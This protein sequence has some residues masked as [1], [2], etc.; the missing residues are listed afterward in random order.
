MRKLL[1]CTVQEKIF[2]RCKEKNY[3][4]VEPFFYENNNSKFHLKC[5]VDNHEWYT[6][7]NSFIN[8]KKGCKKCTGSLKL[9]QEEAEKNILERCKEKNYTLSELFI[10]ENSYSKFHLRCNNDGYE[11]YP[12]YS[13]FINHKKGCSKCCGKL[14]LTQQEVEHNVLKICK[15]KN[16]ELIESFTYINNKT[17][18][19][20]KCN[21]DKYEWYVTYY[22]LINSKTG[23]P[24]CCGKL[25]LT[26]QEAEKN[27]LKKCKE[28]N[29]ELIEPFIYINNETKILLR[30]DVDEYKWYT[31]YLNFI[32][33]DKG[34]P[35]CSGN[36]KHTQQEVEY[37][38][39]KMCK[40]KNYEL[41]KP[42]Q[43]IGTDNTKIF[44]KCNVD[45][46]EWDVKYNNFINQNSGCPKCG[47]KRAA[48]TTI[49]RYGEIYKKLIPRYNINSIIYLDILSE[50]LNLPIQHAL[51]GGEKK[52]VKYWA[53]G[54][55]EKYNICIEWD[56]KFHKNNKFIKKDIIREQFL[57]ENFNCNIIRINEKA[58]LKDTDNQINLI[59]EKINNI[60][61]NGNNISLE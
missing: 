25:K 37:N 8:Y 47:W 36:L 50:K 29:Y 33:N 32:N 43:Y 38:V 17:K 23:C 13:N 26:Q 7:Y 55:I 9:T 45:N 22:N 6:D 14:K 42:I 27:I 40:E 30:C 28:K 2:E 24:K 53:D 61:N 41:I 11:W 48:K 1:N 3:I 54:Y 39:L 18:I 16:Y 34:C 44:L 59:C 31:T 56:E 52:F 10:Y 57:K 4:L 21:I 35:K 49:E 46:Y 51:N 19:H 12:N 5:N 58:F 60:I 20:L 15:E